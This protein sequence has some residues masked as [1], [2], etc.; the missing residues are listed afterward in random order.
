MEVFPAA[1]V[2]VTV[3]TLAPATNDTDA[4]DQLVVP[5]APPLVEL[6]ALTQ[7]IEAI[8]TLS[9]AVP[10]RD[11]AA[12]AVVKVAAAV[13]FVI[14]TV[15]AVVSR[16]TVL[17]VLVEAVLR[18]PAIS[19]APPAGTVAV[20]V[21]SVVNPLIATLNVLGP[22]VTVLVAPASPPAVPVSVTSA[23]VK[24]VTDSLNTTVRLIGCV[25]VGS[26]WP[27]A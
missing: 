5:A 13:G 25:L 2:A 24:P 21:P 12:K 16:V 20:T 6:A 7:L 23:P 14:V 11:I 19:C 1:S 26:I 3:M 27:P 9:A 8:A 15:G 10:P 4:T 17:S 18:F 22:P